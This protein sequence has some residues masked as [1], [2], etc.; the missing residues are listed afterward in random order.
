MRKRDVSHR[1]ARELTQQARQNLQLTRAMLW[2]KAWEHECLRIYDA[3]VREAAALEANIKLKVSEQKTVEAAHHHSESQTYPSNDLNAGTL[4]ASKYDTN[5][6]YQQDPPPHGTKIAQS[7][8][9]PGSCQPNQSP[10]RRPL[11]QRERC[12]RKSLKESDKHLPSTPCSRHGCESPKK[13]RST[14]PR[15]GSQR[16]QTTPDRLP[17][18][19]RMETTRKMKNTSY[20]KSLNSTE[21][22]HRPRPTALHQ[23]GGTSN[24]SPVFSV[25]ECREKEKDSRSN[26]HQGALGGCDKQ[27]SF[28]PRQ[29]VFE[30]GNNRPRQ[31]SS[32]N[33]I[34]KSLGNLKNL[35]SHRVQEFDNGDDDVSLDLAN[36][37]KTPS[38]RQRENVGHGSSQLLIDHLKKLE[39]SSGA[40]EALSKSKS[41]FGSSTKR[42]VPVVRRSMLGPVDR[43]KSTT[44]TSQPNTS[45][46][47]QRMKSKQCVDSNGRRDHETLAAS[48][49]ELDKSWA[50]HNTAS[51]A[52]MNSACDWMSE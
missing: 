42:M 34:R 51:T 28:R 20:R 46:A 15:S 16:I 12:R 33:V 35:P 45:T 30:E 10:D 5:K 25:P 14:A 6:G 24:S 32:P 7:G 4:V 48:F 3:D 38:F 27:S 19:Q 49:R 44:N 23:S 29:K 41:S 43:R 18:A 13:R 36:L 2:S 39:D 37:Q 9:Q 40:I 52:S 22:G 11:L 21:S 17:D 31:R 47:I 1:K 26:W 50:S 8:V